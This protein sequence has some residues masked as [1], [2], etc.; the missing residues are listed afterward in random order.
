MVL[1]LYH[2]Y[3]K[4]MFTGNKDDSPLQVRKAAFKCTSKIIK[5][6]AFDKS[7]LAEQN[8][9]R[10]ILHGLEDPSR[11]VRLAAGYA[12]RSLAECFAQ[13]PT[14]QFG[15][16]FDWI[17][18][19]S[20]STTP[21]GRETLV[22]T[23][24]ILAESKQS[25]IQQRALQ[26]LIL[27][28][29]RTNPFSKAQAA[30]EIFRLSRLRAIAS[31]RMYLPFIEDIAP[32]LL[33]LSKHYP[34]IIDDACNVLSIAPRQF[35]ERT[36]RYTLPEIIAKHD[37]GALED[38]TDGLGIP[39]GRLLFT[40]GAAIL[41]HLY[42]MDTGHMPSLEWMARRMDDAAN[43]RGGIN[44]QSVTRSFIADLLPRLAIKLGDADATVGKQAE[45]AIKRVAKVFHSVSVEGKP[46]RTSVTPD[47]ATFLQGHL[48]TIIARLND[49]LSEA[50]EKSNL[51]TKQSALRGLGALIELVQS[52]S[53]KQHAPQIMV[54]LQ[55]MINLPVTAASALDVW[56]KFLKTLAAEDETVT[57]IYFGTTSATLAYLWPRFSDK[58]RGLAQLIFDY[59]IKLG[60]GHPDTLRDVVS[61]SGV[62]GLEKHA[63]YLEKSRRGWTAAMKFQNI[64]DRLDSP[65]I[66]VAIQSLVELKAFFTTEQEFA[67]S[68]TL[69]D[70]FDP[71]VGQLIT[72]LFMN[73][74]REG[75]DTETL[76]LLA[77]ECIG[78]LGAVD[79]DRTLFP[80]QRA[81][82]VLLEN[83]DDGNE[84]EEFACHVLVNLLVP[85]FRS[86]SETTYQSRLAF[87]IQ[88]ILKQCGFTPD[89]LKTDEIPKASPL[90]R[91]R[92]RWRALEQHVVETVT[93]FLAG[94]F[95]YE[96]QASRQTQ[97][98]IYPCKSTYREWTQLWTEHL[99]SL[100]KADS[101]AGAI[102]RPLYASVNHND[103]F[104][105]HSLLPH[106]VLHHLLSGDGDVVEGIRLELTTVLEDQVN[107][108]S[109]S[110]S[111]KR[112]LSAQA[113]FIL[114]DHLNR[115]LR[116][117]RQKRNTTQRQAE[118][119]GNSK[120][121]RRMRAELARWDKH[122]EQ[123]ESIL[124]INDALMAKA[125]FKSKS[126]ARALMSF[127][128]QAVAMQHNNS[129]ELP[130]LYEKMHELYSHLDEPDGMEGLSTMIPAPSLEHQ[131]LE[132]Q[133][134]GRWTSAQSCWE[135]RLQQSPDNLDCHLGLL[136][137][138]RNLGHYD[139]LSTHVRGVLVRRP[140]W[141]HALARYQVESA[142]MMGAWDEVRIICEENEQSDP[143][144]ALG[145]LI[146][147]IHSGDTAA[148]KE[149]LSTARLI[150][151]A[152][153]AAAGVDGYRRTYDSV[154]DLHLIH[155]LADIY[156]FMSHPK[157]MRDEKARVVG[158]NKFREVL[159]ARLE[160]TL[161][162]FRNREPILSMRRTA[163][164]LSPSEYAKT[165][166]D[167]S[168]LA[169]AKIARRSNQMQVAY[170]ALLQAQ[171]SGYAGAF[172]ESAKVMKG[173]DSSGAVA[174]LRKSM[175]L[176]NQDLTNDR[177]AIAGETDAER[178]LM[179]AKAMT[180][181]ARWKCELQMS[182]AKDLSDE[183]QAAAKIAM[184]WE[185]GHFYFGQFQDVCY[186][187]LHRKD[188]IVLGFRRMATVIDSYANAIKC[189]SKFIYQTVP[190]FL[191]IWWEMNKLHAD[192]ACPL[193]GQK[194][195]IKLVN[196]VNSAADI[197]FR[198]AP[199]YQWY[200]AFP[201]IVSRI[202]A[203]FPDDKYEKYWQTLIVRILNEYPEQAIWLFV[204]TLNS[205]D[206]RREERARNIK[207]IIKAC[208][209]S[210][211]PNAKT[212]MTQ[213]TKLTTDFLTL[214][215]YTPSK[216]VSRMDMEHY[217]PGLLRLSKNSKVIIPLIESLTIRLPAS[218][219]TRDTRY[220]P[221]PP[222]LPTFQDFERDVPVMSSLARPKKISATGSNG[223]RYAF[224]GKPLDDLRKDARVMDLFNIINKLLNTNPDSR[225]RQLHIRT[226]GVMPLNE[227]C[228]LI[229]WIPKTLTVRSAL[230]PNLLS[231]KDGDKLNKLPDDNDA[232]IMFRKICAVYVP[233]FAWFV[234]TF[235]EPSAWLAAR[236]AYA[237]TLAVMSIVGY[238][239]GLGDRHCE[240]ILLDVNTG[241]VMHVDFNVLFDKG[242]HLKI[243]E[244]VPFRLTRNILDGLGITG[245]EG[246][247]RVA[248]ELAMDIVRNNMDPLVAVLEAF[249]HDPL[250]E[251]NEDK[252]KDVREQALKV[253]I[254]PNRAD[255]SIEE[256][257]K[258][259]LDVVK[260]KLRGEYGGWTS[261]FQGKPKPTKE[262]VSHLIADATNEVYLARMY[263][264][265]AAYL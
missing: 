167:K 151:G 95:S 77:F 117:A 109:T 154:L 99:M 35:H 150:L 82:M 105:A 71:A 118:R 253:A 262:L 250:S 170:S 183:F 257:A 226:Y 248:C 38:V 2:A 129:P 48:L 172:I 61:L 65:N 122:L 246:P 142:W 224:L 144:L 153:I 74:A 237:R 54:T 158:L 263:S 137:C 51:A 228:G 85:A 3:T 227:T 28:M 244:R 199:A 97:S 234:E 175:Q 176:F 41:T 37:I 113:V 185:S 230:N 133:A 40:H 4:S 16:L 29:K 163:F 6:G 81:S 194:D 126:Y 184:E 80:T 23:M 25:S 181:L 59:M 110:T 161:P 91:S 229:Q 156:N 245:S 247:Y 50:L 33:S 196:Q 11:S 86:T 27:E 218:S 240:N 26:F 108:D 171:S 98:P 103:V 241:E 55:T 89:L 79:P 124:S 132:H 235:P 139:T 145:R 223:Q 123:I 255:M 60:H 242:K 69:G 193:D 56:L 168:W 34:R 197:A 209:T 128:H 130:A 173:T 222:N 148:I 221:F 115:W 236:I 205:K 261:D 44:A 24:G 143:E 157:S 8:E 76:R 165:E 7:L 46:G 219:S 191:S 146:L 179:K 58:L 207:D 195:Y 260:C 20:D 140:E 166:T 111:D 21:S 75:D 215:E 152:P 101:A 93:P 214:I 216:E 107:L 190:R 32:C 53:I 9:F 189:G 220:Q 251:F 30:S 15:I 177:H 204:A 87:S 49:V 5:H 169:T 174:Q 121:A 78:I 182:D 217:S 73:A 106:L 258:S 114:L 149:A 92:K 259:V 233:Y 47:M 180:L 94:K 19:I 120:E 192:G 231:Q 188:R 225:K 13:L 210:G 147:A 43:G 134:M 136:R 213:C 252:V 64:L 14:Q 10:Y 90:M 39:I 141:G 238:I 159:T 187:G 206:K 1:P 208:K 72:R 232:V 52:S 200:T 112:L 243:A 256:I 45:I 67:T 12:L 249:V 239:L 116:L 18:T 265:W 135:V 131:T 57:T 162:T 160:A 178:Q 201:Q 102:F 138:L 119:Q 84:N 164:R 202:G 186:K 96:P 17:D 22:L 63:R 211:P 155:E 127:E 264:G 254:L 104:V 70:S 88:M 198:Q 100:V 203:D 212:Y 42:M 62:P 66:V 68:L 31:W 36:I 83:F 125:A